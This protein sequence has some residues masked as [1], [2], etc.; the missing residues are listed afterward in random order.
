MSKIM[1]K[2]RPTSP[3]HEAMYQEIIAV[4]RKHE[5]SVDGVETLALLANLIGKL[6]AF[7][8]QRKY[9]PEMLLQL[10]STNLETGNAQA[11]ASLRDAPSG[12]M[13]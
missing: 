11:I 6:M 12:K 7:Q 4:L 1:G 8:D 10:I 9:T 5:D 3:E 13:Q 2:P